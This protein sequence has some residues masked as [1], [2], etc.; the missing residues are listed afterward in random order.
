VNLAYLHKGTC[1]NSYKGGSSRLGGWVELTHFLADL[2]N[3]TGLQAGSTLDEAIASRD[4]IREVL[5]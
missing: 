5:G 2:V 4:R 1:D 3:N